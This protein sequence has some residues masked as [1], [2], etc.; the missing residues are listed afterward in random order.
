MA[1]LKARS[2]AAVY[3]NR[4]ERYGSKKLGPGMG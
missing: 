1:W 3:V 4:G 2:M